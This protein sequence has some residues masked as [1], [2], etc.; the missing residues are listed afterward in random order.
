MMDLSQ[1]TKVLCFNR[2][3]N[4]DLY[5]YNKAEK[6]SK[7]LS[8]ITPKTGLKP[9]ITVSLSVIPS[10]NVMGVTLTVKNM[11][12][13]FDISKAFYMDIA[14][15]YETC[16]IAIYKCVVFRSYQ[17]SPNPDGVYVFEGVVTGD[18]VENNNISIVEEDYFTLDMNNLGNESM[19]SFLEY[20]LNGTSSVDNRPKSK[21]TSLPKFKF[22]IV[23][24][25]NDIKNV[26]AN[27]NI[28]INKNTK[29]FSTPLSRASYAKHVLTEWASKN[30]NTKNY[31]VV[32]EGNNFVISDASDNTEV[33]PSTA[34]DIIGYNSATYN[35]A[36][37]SITMP[38]Y[39]AINAGSLIRCEAG[40]ATQ[41]GLP[42]AANWNTAIR[43]DAY[44]LYKVFRYSVTFSTV[45]ENTM[46]IDAM[47]VI[48]AGKVYV[49][50]DADNRVYDSRKSIKSADNY[51]DRIIKEEYGMYDGNVI[52]G[53]IPSDELVVKAMK[54]KAGGVF[55]DSSIIVKYDNITDGDIIQ[56]ISKQDFYESFSLRSIPIDNKT[57]VLFFK[58]YIL[59]P[60]VFSTTWNKTNDNLTCESNPFFPICF[61]SG[62]MYMPPVGNLVNPSNWSSIKSI[63]ADFIEMYK[64][65]DAYKM[66]IYYWTKLVNES[67]GI[68]I[69]RTRS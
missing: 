30:E 49:D 69:Q 21:K 2:I 35:G 17:V 47:P 3:I 53:D 66:Y 55:V 48:K 27:A 41:V 4:V 14:M 54:N 62:N 68:I 22:N 65:N 20:I 9:D 13:D 10:N 43:N 5:Y 31:I 56:F 67:S 18:I 50:A 25:N 15:G 34:I 28:T 7:Q 60:V 24:A 26:L 23:Y 16:G 36:F 37:L 8:I 29:G 11:V 51:L 19:L 39:P 45:H 1:S 44:S 58:P 33:Y 64:D 52:V 59:F 40:Y 46:T 42:N 61:T 12:I 57:G 63:L 6:Q 38:Y 32:I